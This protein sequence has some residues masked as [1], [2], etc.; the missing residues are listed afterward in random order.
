MTPTARPPFPP[1]S[2]GLS[3]SLH[4]GAANVGQRWLNT[5]IIVTAAPTVISL[6]LGATGSFAVALTLT[7][8]CGSV[9]AAR[10]VHDDDPTPPALWWSVATMAVVAVLRSP[11]GSHDLWSYAFYGR[12][13]SH[14]GVNPYHAVP[15]Q[16]PHDVLS[17]VVRWRHTPS[18]YGPLFTLY[19]AAATRIA[20]NSLLAMRLIFQGAAA[21]AVL[22]C[23]GVLQWARRTRTMMLVALAPFVWVALVNGGHNDALAAAAILAAV[24]AF[25]KQRW[26][27]AGCVVAVAGMI[28]IPGLFIV[29]PFVAVLVVRR[30]WRDAAVLTVGPALAVLASLI[31]LPESLK[32]ASSA[33]GDRI[34][35]ASIW[36]PIQLLTSA[37]APMLTAISTALVL[38][39]IVLI[40]WIRRHD[41][42]SALAAGSS[43]GV[44]GFAAGYTLTW[45][46]FWGLPALALSG[47]FAVTAIVAA[48][49]SLMQASYQL[50]GSGVPT[51]VGVVILSVIAP[52]VLFGLFLQR[53]TA[54][55]SKSNAV[56]LDK[57]SPTR[58]GG[59]GRGATAVV[60]HRG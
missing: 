18:V 54:T 41:R 5:L 16:F 2:A 8:L 10:A 35:R 48:R 45:Y 30:R 7:G 21:V 47:D 46:Q 60:D 1:S 13:W 28:K 6:T 37:S 25:D 44:F 52:V 9:L 22:A 20:G 31:L 23:L 53:V 58:T 39:L 4:D 51:S 49:G 42:E 11:I 24:V 12:M 59:S 15:A 3:G 27:L 29:V 33:T 17:P 50:S 32:N 36:R 55:R 34:S 57:F 38:S 43:V 40:V 19:S 26:L 56:T 14:Y